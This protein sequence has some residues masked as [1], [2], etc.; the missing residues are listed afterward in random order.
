MQPEGQT[1]YRAQGQ[2]HADAHELGNITRSSP[3]RK[4]NYKTEGAFHAPINAGVPTH[5]PQTTR[6][7]LHKK[8]VLKETPELFI[9]SKDCPGP[10]VF[11]RYLADR[12]GPTL[13]GI[14]KNGGDA[15]RS[16]SPELNASV[17]TFVGGSMSPRKFR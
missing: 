15:Q 16:Y 10:R 4:R 14:F 8:I 3:M 17:R 12:K 7:K 5:R 9:R 6:G 1:S 11:E 13:E 2:R